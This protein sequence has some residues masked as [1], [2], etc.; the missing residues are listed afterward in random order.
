MIIVPCAQHI[1]GKIKA[2]PVKHKTFVQFKTLFHKIISLCLSRA[3]IA[4]SAFS[5]LALETE[6]VNLVKVFT[7][8]INL[9][10]N[11]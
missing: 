4:C 9:F 7:R 5:Y 8:A 1:L 11:F 2:T 10:V 3:M 6:T